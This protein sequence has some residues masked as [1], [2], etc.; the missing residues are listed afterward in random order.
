MIMLLDKHEEAHSFY[1][2]VNV[3]HLNLFIDR[4][5]VRRIIMICINNKDGVKIIDALQRLHNLLSVSI[6]PWK[7]TQKETYMY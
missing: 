4:F 5:R 6:K 1:V 2:S 7:E 3:K